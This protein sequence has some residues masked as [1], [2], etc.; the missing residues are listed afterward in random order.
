MSVPVRLRHP[1]VVLG[2]VLS[3]LAGAA[4]IRAA[5]AWTAASSPL[6]VKPPSVEQL[7]ADLAAEQARS[8]DLQLQLGQLVTSSRDL[9]TALETARS[10]IATD[11]EEAR[12][13]QESL[14]AAKDK[15]AT[16]ERTIRQARAAA[17]ATAPP[18]PTTAATAAT[19]TVGA[20]EDA[21]EEH[22]DGEEW[23]DDD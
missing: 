4:T 7:Q 2:V 11:A 10:R 9:V 14:A 13:V 17:A 16:L 22:D 5:A 1:L 15:L 3:L 6:A 23:G 18:P 21:Y 8:A 19:S 20:G 12:T